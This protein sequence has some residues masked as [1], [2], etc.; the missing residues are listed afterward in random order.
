[1]HKWAWGKVSFTYLDRLHV[2]AVAAVP[3]DPRRRVGAPHDARDVV[4]AAGRHRLLGGDDAG[5]LRRN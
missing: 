1:M 3:F 4:G 5:A 2:L